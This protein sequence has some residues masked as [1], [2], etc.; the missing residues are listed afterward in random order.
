MV[1]PER[2]SLLSHRCRPSGTNWGGGKKAKM[3]TKKINK[4][5]F[6][7]CIFLDAWFRCSSA[8]Q[9]LKCDFKWCLIEEIWSK[10]PDYNKQ[11]KQLW[12]IFSLFPSQ[13]DGDESDTVT[14]LCQM[15]GTHAEASHSKL[16]L[17]LDLTL[18]VFLN[19]EPRNFPLS[20]VHVQLLSE[21]SNRREDVEPW[22]AKRYRR[23]E[24]CLLVLCF[25]R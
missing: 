3:F 14:A 1:W 16:E 20:W 23:E 18:S 2:N 25:V 4:L 12:L 17:W 11:L 22:K 19:G 8:V 13:N 5:N 15:N 9:S 6:F 7:H 24:K 21:Q 10:D